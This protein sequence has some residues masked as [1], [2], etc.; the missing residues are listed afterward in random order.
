M[1]VIVMVVVNVDENVWVSSSVKD[2]L[3]EDDVDGVMEGEKETC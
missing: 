2:M 1:N 3:D